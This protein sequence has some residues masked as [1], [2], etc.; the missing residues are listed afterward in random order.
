MAANIERDPIGQAAGC[1]HPRNPAAAGRALRD[2][3]GCYATGVAVVTAVAEDG[4]PFG[5]TINSFSALSLDPPLV[6]WS[7][8]RSS[9]LVAQF[10]ARSRFA[11]NVLGSAQEAIARQ[12][13]APRPDRFAGIRW[14]PGPGGL[15]HLEGAVAY[16]DCRLEDS[17]ATGDHRL[18]IGAVEWFAAAEGEPL[19]FVQGR[20]RT[21]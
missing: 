11:V 16:F 5:L 4:R 1:G 20:F 2:T 6:L 17:H 13:S 3:L 8:R 21:L 18:L 19:L 14:N 15:P 12:F 7:L 10:P 9:P